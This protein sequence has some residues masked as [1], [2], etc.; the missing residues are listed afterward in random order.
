MYFFFVIPV[1][2]AFDNGILY[3]HNSKQT[4]IL[5]A[6]L[7]IDF[8]INLFTTYYEDGKIV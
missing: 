2:I 7:V 4:E 1:E 8:I 5:L 6:V 3:G